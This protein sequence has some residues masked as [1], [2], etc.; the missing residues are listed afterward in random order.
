VVDDE[1]DGEPARL[2]GLLDGRE[3]WAA[4]P[5]ADVVETLKSGLV[6]VDS[7]VLLH[8]YRYGGEARGELLESLRLVGDRLFVPD[9]VAVEFLRNRV[10]TS[11]GEIRDLEEKIRNVPEEMEKASSE[12]LKTGRARGLS[13]QQRDEVSNALHQAAE[14]VVRH[15][16]KSLDERSWARRPSQ[17]DPILSQLIDLLN[18]K[19]GKPYADAEYKKWLAE[20]ERRV[21]ERVAPGFLDQKKEE[22]WGDYMVWRQTLDEAKSRK[23]PVL[24]VSDDLKDDWYLK[25][26][27]LTIGPQPSL[28]REAR[29]EAGAVL[30]LRDVPSFLSL[31]R[32]HLAADVSEETLRE[33]AEEAAVVRK[34]KDESVRSRDRPTKIDEILRRAYQRSEGSARAQS[35]I[36]DYFRANAQ[37]YNA[38]ITADLNAGR[39][40]ASYNLAQAAARGVNPEDAGWFRE[41]AARTPGLEEMMRDTAERN[42]ELFRSTL[43]GTREALTGAEA[44]VDEEPLDE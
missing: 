18:G 21:K 33:A 41:L 43:G 34:A 10:Q 25:I 32:D 29:V 5:D 6:V 22:P 38:G 39:L 36:E 27:G 2:G 11:V 8:L 17:T 15:L 19:V 35:T 23:L 13:E 37:N 16:Q 4:N 42:R 7:N 24:F 26:S 3:E 28:I 1:P 12:L 40:L 31:A 20:G 14:T 30:H 44:E 9:R